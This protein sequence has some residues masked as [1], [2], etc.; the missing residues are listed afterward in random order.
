MNYFEASYY[1]CQSAVLAIVWTVRFP[2]EAGWLPS[3][4]R[5][6]NSKATTQRTQANAGQAHFFVMGGDSPMAKGKAGT[7]K[8]AGF[9]I[10]HQILLAMLLIATIP[11]GGLYYISI[12]KSGQ[13]WSGYIEDKLTSLTDTLVRSVDDWTAFNLS[14]L[15]QNAMTPA[16]LS[17]D[18]EQQNPALKSIQDTYRYTYLAFTIQPNGQ[19]IGRSD[20]KP[21]VYYGDRDY[22]RQVQIGM[23]VGMQVLLGKTSKKPALI[24]AKPI[25]EKGKKIRGVIAIA[26]TLEDL[27]E[28]ITDTRIGET[29]FAILLDRQNRLIAHSKGEVA[30]RL[31]DFSAHPILTSNTLSDKKSFVFDDGPK[32]IVA[33]SKKTQEGW[34][35]IV[36]QDYEE[37]FA[38]SRLAIRNA[39]YLLITTIVMILFIAFLLANRLSKPIQNLTRI[40]VEISLGKLGE[41]IHETRRSEEI[42][43]LA[44]A[45]KRMGVSLQMAI[46][47]LQ[48]R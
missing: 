24:L 38:A 18:A 3:S 45:I 16:I 33:F 20:G 2:C 36:Q 48:K 17:M 40:T 7:Q 21:T 13:Q 47:R 27:S 11:L 39:V 10:L 41:K 12:Y 34:T 37:A 35:L 6:A 19:N 32:K 26:M 28:V 5:K 4:F 30:S 31:Q 9:R 46:D 22:F 43:A 1:A 25:K 44:R 15:E 14:V 29:G 8:K 23:P 42:G